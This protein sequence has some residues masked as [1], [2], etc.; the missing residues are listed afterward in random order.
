VGR[1]CCRAGKNTAVCDRNEGMTE[2]KETIIISG[3]RLECS[4]KI[5]HSNRSR[6]KNVRGR[7]G[8]VGESV[9]LGRIV[10]ARPWVAKRGRGGI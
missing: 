8:G 3:K 1:G 7:R 5:V 6:G 2:E 4:E 10:K 9:K